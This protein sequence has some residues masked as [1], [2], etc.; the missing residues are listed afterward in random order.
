M[1]QRCHFLFVIYDI[2]YIIYTP[3]YIQPYIHIGIYTPTYINKKLNSMN[4]ILFFTTIVIFTTMTTPAIGWRFERFY[5]CCMRGK[6]TSKK[7]DE[8]CK[9]TPDCC[10]KNTFSYNM[11]SVDLAYLQSVRYGDAVPFVPPISCGKVV[12]VYDGDTITIAT[13]YPGVTDSPIY[14]F[15]VRLNGIDS[16]EIKGKT[17]AEKEKAVQ[18]RDALAHLIFEK[19]VVLKNLS[20]EKYGR[21]LADVY[22]DNIHVNQWM[23]DNKYAVPYDGGTK[24]R[25]SDWDDTD[26]RI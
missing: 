14:R 23:L 24:H 21:L 16:A 18:A 4:G 17:F 7:N 2:S 13:K 10:K 12:K 3:V 20:M 25:P 5:R 9:N 11:T 8:I 26:S 22:V 6:R 19:T 1:F 15:S